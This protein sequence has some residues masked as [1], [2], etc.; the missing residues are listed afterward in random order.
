MS[1]AY[2]MPLKQRLIPSYRSWGPGYPYEYAGD[3]IQESIDYV[4]GRKVGPYYDGYNYCAHYT[5]TPGSVIYYDSGVSRRP[6]SPGAEV[7]YNSIM[8]FGSS[9]C[10]IELDFQ[11]N[12]EF[13]ILMFIKEWDE[14]LAS[15]SKGILEQASRLAKKRLT[16]ATKANAREVFDEYGRQTWGVVP[17]LSDINSLVDTLSDIRGGMQ[18]AY[19]KIIGK[20]ITRAKS[21]ETDFVGP[22]CTFKVRGITRISGYI[23]GDYAL[24]QDPKDSFFIFLDEV[25]FHPDLKTVWDGIPF[26]FVADYFLPIGDFLESLHPRGWF[27]PEF[28]IAGGYS[29]KY[30]IMAYPKAP[31]TGDP[32]LIKGFTRTPGVPPNLSSRYPPKINFEAPSPR[33]IFNTL[34]L[35]VSGL[36]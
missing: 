3:L 6:W 5:V 12:D 27:C 25:G 7:P 2:A 10:A 36:R 1:F 18:K 14:T 24:P 16:G 15:F 32:C 19:E 11:Q 35:A 31:H 21:W 4:N 23:T 30:A 33:E 34:Y 17:L 8:Q 9:Q 22:T 26:S 29:I 13:E 28:T 20:R